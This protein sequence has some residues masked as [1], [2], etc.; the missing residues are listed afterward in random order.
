MNEIG[1]NDRSFTTTTDSIHSL[2]SPILKLVISV[3]VLLNNIDDESE[4]RPGDIT[5]A[6]DANTSGPDV[7][8]FARALQV[9][10]AFTPSKA[11]DNVTLNL[12]EGNTL[13]I[14]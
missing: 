13:A 5:E 6:A 10:G 8:T 1:C 2:D 4:K 14:N 3:A 7:T 11:V 9:S 12:A